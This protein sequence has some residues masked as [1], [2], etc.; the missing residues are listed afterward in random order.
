MTNTQEFKYIKNEPD[1][2]HLND[3]EKYKA[4][5]NEVGT[6]EANKTIK[7]REEWM[8]NFHPKPNSTILE[9][10]AH[11]GPNLLHYGRLGHKVT[12]V[13]ISDTLIET[14]EKHKKLESIEVQN[15]ITM[16][17]SWIEDYEPAEEFDYVLVT[18]VLEHVSD[19]VA[20]LKT[21][22]KGL[23]KD[24]YL[25]VSSPTTHWG[26]NTH[27]RGVPPEDLK[28]W[29]DEVGLVTDRL[30]TEDH[31]WTFC[32]AKKPSLMDKVKNIFK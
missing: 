19:P 11:N 32:Y 21:A 8:K 2:S 23:K 24:G 29:I 3:R 28:K 20:I 10:G 5:Y 22:V 27:V 13:D 14:F 26:N 25:Y 31:G 4:M 1:Y 30:F 17:K 6:V 18:E 9:L 7:W 12:G 15:R 16:V